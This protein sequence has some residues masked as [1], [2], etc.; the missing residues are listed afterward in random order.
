MQVLP[1]DIEECFSSFL[2]TVVIAAFIV[3]SLQLKNVFLS[4]IVLMSEIL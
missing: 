1:P 3:F 4:L 2:I